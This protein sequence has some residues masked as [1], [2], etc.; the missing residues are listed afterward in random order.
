MLT[1]TCRTARRYARF[2]LP[3]ALLLVSS[4]DAQKQQRMFSDE[5][6]A[7]QP[8]ARQAATQTL[9]FASDADAIA[10][11]DLAPADVVSISFNGSDPSSYAVFSGPADEFP[12]E[13][14]DFLV[15]GSGAVDNYLMPGQFVSTTIGG[16]NGPSGRDMAQM[17]ITLNVPDGAQTLRFDLKF[18]SEEYPI[19]VGSQYNDYLLVELG[20]STFTLNPIVAPNNVAFDTNGDLISINT[21]G[22]TS[23]NGS[24]A[25][26]TAF[27]NAPD[28]DSNGGATVLLTQ[29]V[30]IP[31]DA[32][33]ITLIVSVGDQGDDALDSAVFLDNFAFSNLDGGPVVTPACPGTLYFSD[34]DVDNPEFVELTNF[35]AAEAPLSGC[36]FAAFNPFTERVNYAQTLAG[37]LASGASVQ[38]PLPANTLPAGPGAFALVDAATVPSGTYVLDVLGEVKA[39]VVYLNENTIF[40]SVPTPPPPTATAR[41]A[42][43]DAGPSFAEVLGQFQ[44][45]VPAGAPVAARAG[46]PDAVALQGVHPNP[47]RGAFHVSFGLPEA[48]DVRL[49]V[50]DVLGREVAV[51]A[52]GAR[53]GGWHSVPVEASLA[54][55]TYVV[56]L[57][58]GGAVATRMV[59]VVQ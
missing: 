30:E 53:D 29:T 25:P 59:T 15:L 16:I 46:A 1:S 21:T 4:A 41:Q 23:V 54:A 7:T 10:A 52:E 42:A 49:T 13:G 55:G 33:T 11:L 28:G 31:D 36:T 51:V 8:A 48:A 14:D 47:A 2:A 32:E 19:F 24:N 58:A 35:G 27:A 34:F 43:P 22:A 50:Y 57:Q 3:L 18:L 5:Y 9:G 39:A 37:A 38:V 17:S 40:G 6:Y 20:T 56:R 45:Q 12:T 44:A 26:Q